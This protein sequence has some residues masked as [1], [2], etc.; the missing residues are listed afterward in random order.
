[1]AC[2]TAN[3]RIDPDGDHTRNERSTARCDIDLHP[4]PDGGRNITG[5]LPELSGVEF[6]EIFAWFLGAEWRCDWA[7]ARQR[8][9]DNASRSDLARTR[10]QRSAAPTP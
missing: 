4:R 5:Y 2:V 1:M 3:T 8:L 7:D 10:A 6:A 9:G